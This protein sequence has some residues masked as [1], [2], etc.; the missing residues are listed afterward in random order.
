M[1]RLFLV[2]IA[3]TL[4]LSASAF[5]TGFLPM[6][7]I[8]QTQGFSV[9]GENYAT[10]TGLHTT[11][12]AGNIAT[13][14]QKNDLSELCGPKLIQ[15]QGS[16]LMQGANASGSCGSIEVQQI[17]GSTGTQGQLLS[18]IGRSSL[19][20][21]NQTL[22]AGLQQSLGISGSNGTGT[23]TQSSIAGQ[24]Q[25]ILNGRTV[26]NSSQTIGAVQTGSVSGNGWSGGSAGG[27]IDITATL[28]QMAN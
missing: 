11:T 6:S 24:C 26:M 9:Y 17:G 12:N 22:G 3:A 18:T 16:V 15:N 28:S 7:G 14:G 21:Q 19:A 23:S 5:A 13:V 8:G 1:S 4:V 27:L 2:C 10:Q 20:T 25:T